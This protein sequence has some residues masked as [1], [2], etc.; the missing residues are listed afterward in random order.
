MDALETRVAVREE[1][2][3][4]SRPEPSG[5]VIF[6]GSGDLSHRKL[7]PALFRLFQR[8]L[9]PA[10][11][12]VLGCLSYG[13]SP[14][15]DEA[16]REAVGRSL[17]AG[18]PAPPAEAVSSFE[19]RCFY[20]PGEYGDPGLYEALG[21]RLAELAETLGTGGRVLFYLAVPPSLHEP[22]VAQLAA[23]GLHE[24][25][26]DG[27]RWARVVVEKPFGR[28]L[29]SARALSESLRARLRE[30][31]IYRI[32]HYLGKETVQNILM[33]RFANAL[34]EP[35]WNRDHVDHVQITAAETVG[36]EH[37]A[38]YYDQAGCL[39]DMFQNHML[40]ML[41]LVAMEPPA[42]FE[43]DRYRD[44]KVKL[45]RALRPFPDA[46]EELDRW[47][48]RGQY[49]PGALGG[50]AVPGYREEPGVAPGSR[51]ETYVALKVLVDNWRWAGVPFYL[52]SGKRLARRVSEIAVAFKPVPHSLFGPLGADHLAPNVLV[53]N[54][55]PEEGISLTL[56]AKRPGPK[57]CLGSLTLHFDYR[58]V[59]GE[60]PPEAY[61]RLLLDAMLGDQTLFVRTD[62]VEAAWSILTGLLHT[63]EDADRCGTCRLRPYPAGSWGPPEADALLAADGRAWR[64]P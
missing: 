57:L 55:Q 31:Q 23:A 35:V 10:D 59:F 12:F 63:W 20:Q 1:F 36:V 5:V 32:D 14:T 4:E 50:K 33:L 17:A 52:R 39:R 21:R 56:E 22:I 30:R 43:A 38:G 27:A 24:E 44:E 45:L 34:F 41:A 18:R 40:Q 7:L 3:L 8:D 25:A 6:G 37:R 46:P 11:F 51:T 42:A 16:F 64:A 15:T 28:D 62:G 53:L 60:D 19:K 61:E 47:I 2:C 54:V 13:D 9:L 58:T 48:V 29:A 26:E 49:D